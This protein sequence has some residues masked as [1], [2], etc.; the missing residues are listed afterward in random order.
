MVSGDLSQSLG[1][2]VRRGDELYRIAPLDEYLV[3]IDVLETDVLFIEEGARGKLVLASLPFS[4]LSVVIDT[5]TP[6][7]SAQNG[8][9]Y[10]LVEARLVN[11]NSVPVAPG[12]EGIVKIKAGEERLIWIWTRRL[13]N[14]G[15]M[16]WWRWAP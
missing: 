12:M 11:P 6:V 2:S 4:E 14:W 7:T 1:Q 10:F 9:N 16:L 13:T 3:E 5:I 8:S 15:Q